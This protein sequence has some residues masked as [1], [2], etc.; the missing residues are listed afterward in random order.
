M[1]REDKAPFKNHIIIIIII[2]K[3]LATR[4]LYNVRVVQL[5][6]KTV[7]DSN[8]AFVCQSRVENELLFLKTPKTKLHG[9]HT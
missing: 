9:T 4:Y 2:I 3:V 7:L 8:V 6:S 5:T 1:T